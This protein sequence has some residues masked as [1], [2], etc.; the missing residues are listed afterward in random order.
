[1]LNKDK[2]IE[3]VDVY[4]EKRKTRDALKR[5]EIYCN[6]PNIALYEARKN[7]HQLNNEKFR[8]VEEFLQLKGNIE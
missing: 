5:L 8:R 3:A 2:K 1:M 4:L 6:L 7:R